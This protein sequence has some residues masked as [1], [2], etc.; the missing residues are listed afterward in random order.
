MVH[1]T[2]TFDF[3]AFPLVLRRR[4]D[5][6]VCP[7]NPSRESFIPFP[8]IAHSLTQNR[9]GRHSNPLTSSPTSSALPSSS[10]SPTWPTNVT[11]ENKRYPLYTNR[12]LQVVLDGTGML[13]D[14]NTLSTSHPLQVAVAAA[15]GGVLPVVSHMRMRARVG[16]NGGDRGGGVQSGMR[17]VRARVL[18]EEVWRRSERVGKSGS[19]GQ[20]SK[21]MMR[22]RRRKEGYSCSLGW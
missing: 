16:M 14:G 7:G 10:T 13:K 18:G 22:M 20:S 1:P 2:G 17:K 19:R 4:S 6:R 9:S 3:D 12:S 5:Q 11:S 8:F 21:S 15:A